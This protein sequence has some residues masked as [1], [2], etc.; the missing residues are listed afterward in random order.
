L[1]TKKKIGVMLVLAIHPGDPSIKRELRSPHE[2]GEMATA[3]TPISP[4]D[5]FLDVI[6]CFKNFF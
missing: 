3:Y 6:R 4:L 1:P 5:T 2:D